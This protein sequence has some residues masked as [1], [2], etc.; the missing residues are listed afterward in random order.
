MG[1]A[2]QSASALTAWGYGR[3]PAA[4]ELERLPDR[5]G[6][7]SLAVAE[8]GAAR[9]QVALVSRPGLQARMLAETLERMGG[10]RSELIEPQAL[11]AQLALAS[12]DLCIVDWNE[13]PQAQSLHEAWQATG[14][15]DCRRV[16]ILNYPDGADQLPLLEMPNVVGV[17]DERARPD[18]L[19]RG[20]SAM[21]EGDYW[22]RREALQ[23]FVMR[24][25]RAQGARSGGTVPE[26]LTDRERTVLLALAEGDSNDAIA[27]RLC[28]SSHTVKTHLYNLYRKLEVSN[29]VEA[30]LWA[31]TWLADG[32]RT[33]QPRGSV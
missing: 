8:A 11:P 20:V 17:L 14:L 32:E 27:H 28:V 12:W 26:A 30:G 2:D 9:A 13:L 5:G 22:F 29:R 4:A 15:E 31:R 33:A 7:S 16:A 10:C 1:L 25:R 18:L 23:R 24:T 6:V 3:A 21:L 19:L